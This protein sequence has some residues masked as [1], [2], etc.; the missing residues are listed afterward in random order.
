MAVKNSSHHPKWQ[1]CSLFNLDLFD[2]DRKMSEMAPSTVSTNFSSISNVDISCLKK[3][4]IQSATTPPPLLAAASLRSI[5]TQTLNNACQH[6]DPLNH[7]CSISLNNYSTKL[8]HI[9]ETLIT[10]NDY[11]PDNSDIVS[12]T[13]SLNRKIMLGST[14]ILDNF[15]K[16]SLKTNTNVG[17]G[18]VIESSTTQRRWHSERGAR[19]PN[20]R[21]NLPLTTAQRQVLERYLNYPLQKPTHI[22]TRQQP[23]GMAA[24]CTGTALQTITNASGYC[25]QTNTSVSNRATSYSSHSSMHRPLSSTSSADSQKTSANNPTFVQRNRNSFINGS[26]ARALREIK[27]KKSQQQKENNPLKRRKMSDTDDLKTELY[28]IETDTSSDEDDDEIEQSESDNEEDPVEESGEG[29]MQQTEFPTNGTISLLNQ[30]HIKSITQSL[31][32]PIGRELM[33][34]CSICYENKLLQLRTCCEFH[35]CN[36]CMN[37][38]IEHQIKQGVVKIQCPNMLCQQYIHRD[39]IITRLQPELREKFFHFLADVNREINVKTCP[40]CSNVHEIDRN[41]FL[42]MRRAPTKVQCAECNLIWCFQCHAPWHDGITCK[43]FRKGDRMLKTWA[44]EVHYGQHNAVSCP[45]CKIYIQRTKGDHYSE[46]SVLGCKYRFYPDKPFKRRLIRGSILGGKIIAAP[47][48]VCFAIAAA[49]V[50]ASVAVIAL[51]LYG[52]FLL[53]RQLKLKRRACRRQ[54]TFKDPVLIS[55][56]AFNE[57]FPQLIPREPTIGAQTANTITGN[58]SSNSVRITAPVEIFSANDQEDRRRTTTAEIS[59]APIA[60]IEECEI[61]I[62]PESTAMNGKSAWSRYS[63]TAVRFRYALS[64]KVQQPLLLGFKSYSMCDLQPRISSNEYLHLSSFSPCSLNFP[65]LTR[66]SPIRNSS[67]SQLL[68]K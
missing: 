35:V 51:P 61:E 12:K 47:L 29:E 38:Y 43:E 44:K 3:K 5:D 1:H 14:A 53:A 19:H 8:E 56:K 37:E 30:K 62:H 16:N 27:K 34:E 25:G 59:G 15:L 21:A 4:L 39:E 46:F 6:T 41:L 55:Y 36:Y 42:H 54:K 9:V 60:N 22:R 67:N 49:C 20:L 28:G 63:A 10:N 65:R 58:P 11:F 66:N 57:M 48:I 50:C 7:S 33:S 26:R 31:T 23:T 45:R 52:S 64:S 68:T 32:Y 17:N 24:A 2:D 40:R 13:H 18:V